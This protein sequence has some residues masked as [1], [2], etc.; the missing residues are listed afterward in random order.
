ML[1]LIRWMRANAT[2][3]AGFD[4]SRPVLLQLPLLSDSQLRA[5][6]QSMRSAD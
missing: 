3:I 4:V 5:A 6:F 1:G 2:G